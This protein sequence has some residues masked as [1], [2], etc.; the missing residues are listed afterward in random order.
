MLFEVRGKAIDHHRNATGYTPILLRANKTAKEFVTFIKNN[1]AKH[2][3]EGNI[4]PM[5][6]TKVSLKG[7]KRPIIAATPK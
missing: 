2:M 1:D 5:N 4:Y 3:E 7:N 6:F